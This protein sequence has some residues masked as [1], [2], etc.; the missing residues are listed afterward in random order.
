MQA[1]LSCSFPNV[2]ILDAT[3]SFADVAPDAMCDNDDDTFQIEINTQVTVGVQ[4]P[5]T[6]TFSDGNGFQTSI[7]CCPLV[8]LNKEV[9]P[10]PMQA[11]IS[12]TAI[13]TWLH[14]RPHTAGLKSYLVWELSPEPW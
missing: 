10:V 4:I 8:L 9:P 1:T 5:F 13:R 11:A 12:A 7:S 6:V 2:N 3:A 14:L